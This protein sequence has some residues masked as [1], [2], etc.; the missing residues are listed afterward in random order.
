MAREASKSN[1]IRVADFEKKYLSGKVIDIGGSGDP[2]CP[3]AEVFDLEQ[4][5]ANRISDFH[6]SE[7]YDC[8]HSSHCLEHMFDPQRAITDWWALVKKGGYLITVVPH[9]DL[10]EQKIWP[11]AFNSDHKATFRLGGTKSWSPVSYDLESLCK[12]LPGGRLISLEIQDDNYDHD[13][14]FPKHLSHEP[15]FLSKHFRSILKRLPTESPFRKYIALCQ[16]RSGLPVDQT[17]YFNALAQ[18]EAIVQK[19]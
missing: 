8:V 10:Y 6:E 3:W 13:L 1:Q 5:D 18:I 17:F 11:S 15:T 7:T 14:I 12:N 19:V 16:I 4:G 9:E 2:V